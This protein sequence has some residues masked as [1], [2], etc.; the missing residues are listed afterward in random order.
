[1]LFTAQYTPKTSVKPPAH[2]KS[3]DHRAF[4]SRKGKKKKRMKALPSSCR[5]CRSRPCRGY[6]A[7][8]WP[9]EYRTRARRRHLCCRVPITRGSRFWSLHRRKDGAVGRQR[10]RERMLF[11]QRG[12]DEV[13]LLRID[14]CVS[15]LVFKKM[16]LFFGR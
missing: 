7:G 9:R 12:E 5:N 15:I 6:R 16:G 13:C 14:H 1:M 2:D 10:L 3:G 4:F 8:S 11:C